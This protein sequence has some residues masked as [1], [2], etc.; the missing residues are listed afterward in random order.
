MADNVTLPGTGAVI[1]ADDVSGVE[2]Q[3]VKLDVGGDGAASPVV[4]NGALP[5]GARTGRVI[6]TP[7]V[8]ATPDYADG[9]VIGGKIT[10]DGIGRVSDG[11]GVITSVLVTCDV[12]IAAGNVMDLLIFSTDPSN[13][14]FTDNSALA[15]NVADLHFLIDVIPLT[16]RTDL[17]TP[18]ALSSGPVNIP[19]KCVSGTDDLY[20]VLVNR[21]VALNLGGT[22][23]INLIVNALLD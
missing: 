22:S 14:T 23:D 8:S 11:T 18:A 9:D 4:G 21:S 7:T 5:V 19:F 12:D 16:V 3:R 15:V 17:G 2:Y 10:L 6:V 20:A 1:A 13:S